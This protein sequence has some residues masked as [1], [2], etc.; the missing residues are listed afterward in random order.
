MANYRGWGRWK[1]AKAALARQAPE[2]D[3]KSAVTGRL[4][5][6]SPDRLAVAKAEYDS[7]LWDGTARRADGQ[8]S[9]A[10]HLVTKKGSG[11]RPCGDFRAPNSRTIPNRCP[12]PHIQDYTHHLSGCTIF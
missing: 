6:R 1:E 5:R 7:M 11:W 4:R 9:S 3:Q 8:W 10:L 2:L 12:V